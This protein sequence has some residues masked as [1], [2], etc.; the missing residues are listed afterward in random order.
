VLKQLV[1]A[2][3][4]EKR[5]ND[6]C[7]AKFGKT[8]DEAAKEMGGGAAIAMKMQMIPGGTALNGATLESLSAKVE[9]DKATLMNGDK[10]VAD[11]VKVDGSWKIDA[12][13]LA[14]MA[15]QLQ[16]MLPMM[17]AMTSQMDALAADVEAGKFTS[18]QE[19]FGELAKRMGI[20]GAPGAPAGG[21]D[22]NK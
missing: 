19:V 22:L 15:P 21:T 10:K 1:N 6:A 11:L 2:A 4:P 9:G 7:K 14:A 5:L 3:K 12:P 18:I 8:L 17:T 13:E 16:A 20:P